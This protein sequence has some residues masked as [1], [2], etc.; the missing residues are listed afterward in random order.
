MSRLL[1]HITTGDAYQMV[2]ERGCSPEQRAYMEKNPVAAGPGTVVG[3]A[4]ETRKPVY[5][6]DVEADP[7]FRQMDLAM[8]AGFRAALGVPLLREGEIIGVLML[9]HSRPDTFT[10]DHI[11][12]AQTFADQ[13]VIAIEN[14]RLF[15]VEQTRTK[16]LQTRS[17]ELAQSLEYQTAISNVLSVISR[18]PNQLQPVLDEIARTAA[19]L[20]EASNSVISLEQA[21]ELHLVAAHGLITKLEKGPID[22]SWESG[23]AYIDRKP[24]HVH[25]MMAARDEFPLGYEIGQQRGHRTTLGLPLL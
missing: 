11:E 7:G 10:A 25:D 17:A 3:R 19:N 12:R 16:E 20:C 24:V 14:A 18:S 15:E 23:R 2:A 8:G 13:A 22:R 21:G 1:A 6:A 4:A 9:L 5:V